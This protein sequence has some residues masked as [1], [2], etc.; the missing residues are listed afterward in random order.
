MVKKIVLK[1]MFI[2][3]LVNILITSFNCAHGVSVEPPSGL[4]G[5]W[6]GDN[7]ASDI[8][9]ANDGTLMNGATFAAG[10]VDR[11]FSFDGVD[12]YVEVTDTTNFN[13]NQ[14]LTVEA[15]VFL[16]HNNYGGIIGQWGY[17]GAGGDAFMLALDDS[18]LRGTL[19]IQGLYHLYS[20][21][22]ILINTWTHV[23]MVY[24]GS[25][26]ELYVNGALD[27]S[28]SISVNPVA[29]SQTVKIGLEDIMSG[30]KHYLDGL[31]DE[32]SIYNRDL[33]PSEIQSIYDAGSSGKTKQ[34][35]DYD[36][37]IDVSGSGSTSPSVGVHTY[38]EG[39]E[40]P[41][42]ASPSSGWSFSHWLL[43]SVNVGSDNPLP[44][45]M[46][47][48][49]TLTAVFTEVPAE[50]VNPP[51]FSP[52]GGTYSSPQSIEISCSTSDATIRYTTDG[53]I[54]TSSSTLYMDPI[55]VDS[56]VVTIM[57]QA[58]KS[59]MLDSVVQ[60]ATYTI[61]STG[62]PDV[63][64][65]VANAG[66][67]RT[68]NAGST[69]PFS[70]AS[71]SDNV[72]IESYEWD[73]GDDNTATGITTNHTYDAVGDYIVTLT[74]TDAAGNS[75]TVTI[76]ITVKEAEAGGFPFWILIPIII[77]VIVAVI[78][79]WFFF[80]KKR[81]PKEKVP[82][83]SKIRVTVDPNELLADGKSKSS[84]VIE[85]LDAEGKPVSALSDTEIKL[86][87]TKGRIEKP[88]VKISKGKEKEQ[89]LLV[90][91]KEGGKATLSAIVE[92]LGSTSVTVTFM[93]KK[94]YCMHCGSKMSLAA[95]HCSVCGKS[96]PAGVDTKACKNCNAVIPVVAKFC[97]ECGAAQPDQE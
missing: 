15:W 32:V 11:A 85:L 38:A 78:L 1:L 3:L 97:A 39:T 6:P 61:E 51:T 28:E 70:A 82:K 33:N 9:G 91:P 17:G 65:P 52:V 83:P 95:K 4:V 58:F 12:D 16:N 94:R 41:V 42:T 90:S 23:A 59:G 74:V 29:S 40:V 46:N 26:L 45:T 86:V 2:L 36:L 64:S 49:H 93:E 35:P 69:V 14:P 21:S 62:E 50:Q 92:D 88:V 22:K 43:D 84:I 67:D 13:F 75:D 68:V 24:D 57:A 5:W 73:F 37:T 96:P 55:S 81:K 80:L 47:A 72:G 25:Q 54:P 44:V 63:T 7:N 10:K 76:L 30:G 66:N 79:I 89:T 77:A 87:T 34:E 8:I 18:Y 71:S 20:N 48:P 56:G 19:P 27:A 60:Q 31:I 53:T